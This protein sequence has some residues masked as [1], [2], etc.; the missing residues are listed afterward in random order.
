MANSVL[1]SN[2][3][4]F[5]TNGI[6]NSGHPVWVGKVALWG[7]DS[8]SAITVA[9]GT[10]PIP[11]VKISYSSSVNFNSLSQWQE[12]TL[13]PPQFFTSLSVLNV[14]NGSGYIFCV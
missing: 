13:H 7:I 6:V 14:I 12:T 11:C 3:Y 8:S 5:D 2:I 4:Y 10:S 9:P 1:G